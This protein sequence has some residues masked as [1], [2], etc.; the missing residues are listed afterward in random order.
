ML[1]VLVLTEAAAWAHFEWAFEVEEAVVLVDALEG[2]VAALGAQLFFLVA[3]V[4]VW[5]GEI[6][7]VYR[8][9]YY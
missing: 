8:M 5:A 3:V 7:P 9:W 1:L 4:A 6:L 2:E